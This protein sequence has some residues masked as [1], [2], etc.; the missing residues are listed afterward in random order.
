VQKDFDKFNKG[1]ATAKTQ[2][3][4]KLL[5]IENEPGKALLQNMNAYSAVF[6]R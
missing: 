4:Q 3:Q 5:D 1:A 2:S 6:Q